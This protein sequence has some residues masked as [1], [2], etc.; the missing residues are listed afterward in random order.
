MKKS[1]GSFAALAIIACLIVPGVALAQDAKPFV[2]T[3]EGTIDVMG[4]LIDIILE[5]A[6]EGDQ[7]TGTVDVPGQGAE[8]LPLTEFKI[9]GKKITFMIDYPG[10]PGEPTFDGELD[11][12]GIT[13]SG[14]FS[15]S[16]EE[17]TFE[18]KKK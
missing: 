5:F 10:L 17:G 15:Q 13:L 16:G 3:W 12:A 1:F 7:L 4:Q 8:D 14:T 6:L 18:A 9:E 2:G 11:A